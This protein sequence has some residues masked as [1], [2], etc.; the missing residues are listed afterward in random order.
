MFR[1]INQYFTIHIKL[2]MRVN[3]SAL[4]D[5]GIFGKFIPMQQ[6]RRTYLKMEARVW[7]A[8][9]KIALLISPDLGQNFM[10]IL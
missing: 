2:I 8:E 6:I 1:L 3:F 7:A 4:L 9:V 5:I 10:M